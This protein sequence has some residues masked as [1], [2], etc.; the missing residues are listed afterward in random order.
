MYKF[1]KTF[2]LKFISL[3]MI[4]LIAIIAT[5]HVAVYV[6]TRDIIESE[7]YL[8]AQG[9]AVAVAHSVMLEIEDYKAFIADIEKYKSSIE[10]EVERANVDKEGMPAEHYRNSAYYQKMQNFFTKIKK[11]SHVKYIY[12]ERRID[13]KN[14][15]FILDSEPIGAWDHSPPAS[16]HPNDQWRELTYSTGKPVGFKLTAYLAWGNLIGAYAPIF[17]RDGKLL[18]IA[19]VNIDGSHLYRHLR[20]LQMIMFAV[21]AFILG[22]ALLILMRHSDAILEPMLKDKLTGAYNKRYFEKLLQ[23]EIA[24]A[25]KGRRYL[26]LLMFDLD[27]FK[28]INDTY[29][30][31]FGDQVL[32]SVSTTIRNSLRQ[33][34]H[35]VRYGGEEFVVIVPNANEKRAMEI[36]ERIRHAIEG[37][38]IHN[39][40]RDISVKISI[41]VG[42]AN[43]TR[44]NLSAQEFLKNA[45]KALYEAKKTRNSVAV[46]K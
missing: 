45:D 8:N 41:S 5:V 9:I 6:T 33:N 30:H 28:K 16:F 37:N 42:I 13:D 46:F 32:S 34:D 39:D 17:D 20:F 3:C 12:T 2:E 26:A 27:H 10:N 43:L 15:E 36:A 25:V 14:I 21:Y 44:P 31:S 22:A 18:G 29:G 24:Y 40:E 38:E 4:V 19:G 23:E 11:H 1:Q 35:F 7:I